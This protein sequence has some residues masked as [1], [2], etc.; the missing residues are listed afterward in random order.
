M[1]EFPTS[2]YFSRE[3]RAVTIRLADSTLTWPRYLIQTHSYGKMGDTPCSKTQETSRVN[4]ARYIPYRI[5]T[6]VYADV[7]RLKNSR[8]DPPTPPGARYILPSSASILATVWVNKSELGSLI[9]ASHHVV[10]GGN[11][12]CCRKGR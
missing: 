3:Q 11:T 9:H 10:V 12:A 1:H 8:P 7:T 6:R 2:E 4:V 5:T